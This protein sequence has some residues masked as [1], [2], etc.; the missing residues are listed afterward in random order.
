MGRSS[1][2]GRAPARRP[3]PPATLASTPAPLEGGGARAS[4]G[5]TRHGALQRPPSHA[6]DHRL[7][8]AGVR[9]EQAR[10]RA[11]ALLLWTVGRREMIPFILLYLGV[12]TLT[13][14]FCSDLIFSK[15][16]I[17]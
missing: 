17:L 8:R 4:E 13:L 7:R 11:D 10:H 5:A 3:R 1:C 6:R 12:E 15:T 9:L 2:C 16:P 14:E